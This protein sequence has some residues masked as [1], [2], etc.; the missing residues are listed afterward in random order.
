MNKHTKAKTFSFCKSTHFNSIIAPCTCCQTD[1]FHIVHDWLMALTGCVDEMPT[2]QYQFWSLARVWSDGINKLSPDVSCVRP[3]S[4][5]LCETAGIH[6]QVL[7]PIGDLHC[8]NCCC[9]LHAC[10]H[11]WAPGQVLGIRAQLQ[12]HCVSHLLSF[13]PPGSL[14]LLSVVVGEG[15]GKGWDRAQ[16]LSPDW[17]ESLREQF[18]QWWQYCL[19]QQKGRLGVYSLSATVRCGTITSEENT[20]SMQFK[21]EGWCN[22]LC[23]WIILSLQA[24]KRAEFE[25]TENFNFM[26]KICISFHITHWQAAI[27]ETF[28]QS[29]VQRGLKEC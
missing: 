11:I 3:V 21:L 23:W 16:R 19:S 28:H 7:G 2:V 1:S 5:A 27:S 4:A 18:P 17:R 14:G 8:S 10:M 15:V 26:Q 25:R 13:L 12:A 24:G 29:R 6:L 22:W 9:C 20:S